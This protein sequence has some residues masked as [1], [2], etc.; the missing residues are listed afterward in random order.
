MSSI[1]DNEP[2]FGEPV[3]PV[4]VDDLMRMAYGTILIDTGGSGIDSL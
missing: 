1:A 4:N 3:S 2:A